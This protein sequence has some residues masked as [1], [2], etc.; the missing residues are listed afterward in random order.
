MLLPGLKR[1]LR[2]IKDLGSILRQGIGLD[3]AKI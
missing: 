1:V 2:E 3:S